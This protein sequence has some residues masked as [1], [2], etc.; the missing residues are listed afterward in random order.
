MK[1]G[2]LLATALASMMV[3]SVALAAPKAHEHKA[4][5]TQKVC[6]K[7]KHQACSKGIHH[8]KY[9]CPMHAN[10]KKDKPGKCP[11]CGMNLT[12]VNPE[13]CQKTMTPVQ[14][15]KHCK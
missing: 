1:K 10:V 13:K 6:E 14:C 15:K 8:A 11:D 4:C 12:A 5:T 9:T 3:A 7:A 2:I